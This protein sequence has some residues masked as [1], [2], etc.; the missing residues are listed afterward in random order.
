MKSPDPQ[1]V[2]SNR[3]NIQK[4]VLKIDEEILRMKGS[5]KK[6]VKAL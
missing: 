1:E 6:P 2:V 4:D 3:Q 5:R